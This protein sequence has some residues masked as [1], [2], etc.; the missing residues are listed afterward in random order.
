MDKYDT[1]VNSVS[2]Q[3]ACFPCSNLIYNPFGAV[4]P[5][6]CSYKLDIELAFIMCGHGNVTEY[7]PFPISYSWKMT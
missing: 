6:L 3:G 5:Y 4:S 7:S 2:I 1:A